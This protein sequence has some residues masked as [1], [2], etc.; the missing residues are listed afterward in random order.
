MP[1]SEN[2][3]STLFSSLEVSGWHWREEFIYAPNATMWLHR[4][5][6]W[7]GELQEFHDRMAGRLVRNMEARH[8]HEGDV[9]HRRLVSDTSSLVEMLVGMLFNG[10]A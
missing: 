9:E 6:P 8:M 7:V 10:C 2:Q 5:M 3:C 1:L 4:D